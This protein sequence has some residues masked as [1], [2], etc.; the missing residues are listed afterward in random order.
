MLWELAML[1][2]PISMINWDYFPFSFEKHSQL[3]RSFRFGPGAW[4]CFISRGLTFWLKQPFCF[5][6][7]LL[8]EYWL[9]SDEQPDWSWVTLPSFATKGN[10]KRKCTCIIQRKEERLF[11]PS[12]KGGPDK[13]CLTKFKLS[14][15]EPFSGLGLNLWISM[16]VSALSKNPTK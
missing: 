2:S 1:W 15:S 6:Q 11:F 4:V 16:S 12:T 9:L 3:H 5:Y 13:D 10:C 14:S 8:F 7:H